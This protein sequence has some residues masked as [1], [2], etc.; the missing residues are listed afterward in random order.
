MSGVRLMVP[1]GWRMK[2]SV[3]LDGSRVRRDLYSKKSKMIFS[4][5]S[6]DVCVV[7]VVGRCVM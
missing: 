6:F 2:P 1:L 3:V 5:K 4:N 7:V